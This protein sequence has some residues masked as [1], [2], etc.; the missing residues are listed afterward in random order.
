MDL[1]SGNELRSLMQKQ[2]GICV[3]LYMPTLRTATDMQQNH[4]RYKNLLR[5]AE[6]RLIANQLSSSEAKS[7]M[8]PAQELSGDLSFWRGQN[9]GLAVF[10][11]AGLL[12]YYR[13]PKNF[14]ELIVVTD[15][16]HLKPLIPIVGG[17]VEFYILAISQNHVRLFKSLRYRTKEVILK[18]LPQS[19]DTA[20]NLDVFEKHLQLH[21]GTEDSKANILRFFQHVDRSLHDFLVDKKSPL[22]FAGVDYL[23]PIYKEA[24][25]YPLLADKC[26]SGNPKTLGPDELRELAWPIVGPFFEKKKLDAI[27][28]YRKNGGTGLVS[29]DLREVI[30]AAYHG[31]VSV[32]FVSVG[33]QKWGSFDPETDEVFLNEKPGP[34]HE[35][36]LDFAATQSL[37]NGGTVYA[38]A[39]EEVPGETPMA[40]IFRY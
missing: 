26:I 30:K 34:G 39:P 11:S 24:N 14:D 29:G 13:L 1:L 21:T 27:E 6:K 22:V 37:L 36:L 19:L 25:T 32:L 16:F 23:F 18:D 12:K 5:E 8:A 28:E 35:D 17:G 4:I 3:S 31:R 20:L 10:L 33:V 9:D 40:A 2:M 15:H 38:V 7:L